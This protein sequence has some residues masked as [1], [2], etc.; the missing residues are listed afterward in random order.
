MSKDDLPGRSLARRYV[1]WLTK[2]RENPL[3]AAV[4]PASRAAEAWLNQRPKDESHRQD[5]VIAENNR[6]IAE[7]QQQ[8]KPK[9]GGEIDEPPA[10]PNA[11]QPVML[12]REFSNDEEKA[13]Y[14][15]R[16]RQ[17]QANAKK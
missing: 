7:A 11:R 1:E 9:D 6:K 4:Q 15:E 3:P 5:E 8:L 16:I 2:Q 10:D 13:A 12:Q 14:L 17:A